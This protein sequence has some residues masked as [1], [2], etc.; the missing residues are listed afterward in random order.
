MLHLYSDK[1][2]PPVKIK[3]EMQT[4]TP[5]ITK[6]KRANS[7]IRGGKSENANF[8]IDN[9]LDTSNLKKRLTDKFS[10]QFDNSHVGFYL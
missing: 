10:S 2:K 8:G 3:T 5:L 9:E 4:L 6:K 7:V 1:L